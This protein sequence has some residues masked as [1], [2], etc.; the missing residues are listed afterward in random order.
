MLVRLGQELTQTKVWFE[1]VLQRAWAAV[2]VDGS[3][4]WEEVALAAWP[5]VGLLLKHRVAA[6]VELVLSW[7]VGLPHRPLERQPRLEAAR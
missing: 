6:I 2:T 4:G 3:E 1:D 5:C 7:M